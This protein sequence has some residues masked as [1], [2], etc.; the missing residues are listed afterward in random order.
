MVGGELQL[1][2]G[3]PAHVCGV[4]CHVS[5]PLPRVTWSLAAA[6]GG[7]GSPTFW[8]S[9]AARCGTLGP[10]VGHY[11][12]WSLI[13][14]AACVAKLPTHH[15]YV[16]LNSRPSCPP[17]GP[18]LDVG[19]HWHSQLYIDENLGPLRRPFFLP[20][21]AARRLVPHHISHQVPHQVLSPT[22]S[23]PQLEG[24]GC[25]QTVADIFNCIYR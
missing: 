16:G 10:K 20:L 23:E 8:C 3:R 7:T 13:T 25:G 19:R 11:S 15:F 24:V 18:T 6:G 14:M 22:I 4:T 21:R 9:A 5:R 12:V 2:H 17:S 1:A